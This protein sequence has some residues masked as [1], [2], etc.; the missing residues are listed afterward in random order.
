M[1]KNKKI[2]IAVADNQSFFHVLGDNKRY[3]DLYSLSHSHPELKDYCLNHRYE[4]ESDLQKQNELI[5]NE[6]Q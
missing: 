6:Y 2:T 1:E 5:G 3:Y 4:L